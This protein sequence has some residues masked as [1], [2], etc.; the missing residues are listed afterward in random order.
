M[1]R[2]D[3]LPLDA[4]WALAAIREEMQ[5]MRDRGL[6]GWVAARVED[7]DVPVVKVE[8]TRKKPA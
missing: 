1:E 3:S 8:Y 7:D 2:D 6:R 4:E 5:L